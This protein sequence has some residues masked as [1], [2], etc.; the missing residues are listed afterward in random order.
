MDI[1]IQLNSG[2]KYSFGM[3]GEAESSAFLDA[4]KFWEVFDNRI[5]R[6]NNG[7][8]CWTFNPR[9]IEL[10]RFNH[11]VGV[12]WES[13]ENILTIKEVSE[14]SYWLLSGIEKQT[15]KL[16][17]QGRAVATG[18]AELT[19]ASA[20]IIYLEFALMLRRP[21]EQLMDLSV[22]F[23]RPPFL[24]PYEKGGFILLNPAMIS[25]FHINPAMSDDRG[26]DWPMAA[27]SET[28]L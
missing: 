8:Q 24:I 20:S 5:L 9:A 4:L 22:I 2:R 25:M 13:P 12:Q 27:V 23:Q 18:F 21:Q 1:C 10:I 15:N 16:N 28:G 17:K 7:D 3:K 26:S 11:T 14:N 6:I 19:L